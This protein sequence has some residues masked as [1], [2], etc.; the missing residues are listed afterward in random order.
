MAVA[1][2]MDARFAIGGREAFLEVYE[3]H[4]ALVR[5]WVARFFS[6]SP[7]EQ[8]EAVQE[9]W[10]TAHRMQQQ[11][12]PAR[13]PLL[14][15]LR[16]LSANRCRE[17]LRAQSRRPP[18]GVPLEDVAEALWLD[19]PLPDAQAHASAVRV[20]VSR[21][22]AS[23]PADEAKVLELCFVEQR[24]HP[25]IAALLGIDERRSKY[26]KQK[27][28]AAAAKDARLLALMREGKA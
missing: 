8:E 1:N 12:E 7:F 6:S 27:L 20:E 25:E 21:F 9:V 5:R 4:R 15:W 16:T 23:L 24:S 17:L 2:L 22:A 18:S 19:E 3:A 10:L 26:L 13:G 14:P 28:L 11:Y